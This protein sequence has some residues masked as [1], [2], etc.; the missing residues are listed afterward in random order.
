MDL[1]LLHCRHGAELECAAVA[2]ELR[3]K[4]KRAGRETT[5]ELE[6][7]YVI[8]QDSSGTKLYR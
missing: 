5:G 1:Q 6:L 7:G 3:L 2:V 8:L 4:R